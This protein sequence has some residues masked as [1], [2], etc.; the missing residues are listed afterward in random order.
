MESTTISLGAETSLL[1][2]I[3]HSLVTEC[4]D[5]FTV[6]FMG[7]IGK[8]LSLVGRG[9]EIDDTRLQALAGEVDDGSLLGAVL[10][11]VELDEWHDVGGH[12][13]VGRDLFT[14]VGG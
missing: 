8:L 6:G 12:V 4:N 9:C 13:L 5:E 7:N 1:A 3:E 14:S 11:H 10:G 2:C